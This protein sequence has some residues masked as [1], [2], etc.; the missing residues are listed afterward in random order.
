MFSVEDF[1]GFLC[2]SKSSVAE[3]AGRRA[4]WPRSGVQKCHSERVRVLG[5]GF[6]GLG[7]PNEI[8]S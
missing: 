6:R 5:F 2:R 8:A 1:W 7:F 3:K 4:S